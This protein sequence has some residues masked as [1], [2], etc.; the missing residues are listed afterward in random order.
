MDSKLNQLLGRTVT[1][2]RRNIRVMG[3]LYSHRGVFALAMGGPHFI[4]YEVGDVM[5]NVVVLRE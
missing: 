1:L 5:G 4:P 2:I 3:V